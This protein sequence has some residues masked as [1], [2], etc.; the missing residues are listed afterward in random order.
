MAS[1]YEAQFAAVVRRIGTYARAHLCEGDST[2][3]VAWHPENQITVRLQLRGDEVWVVAGSG[4]LVRVVAD[5]FGD[6]LHDELDSIVR[7]I[8]DGYATEYFGV[9]GHPSIADFATGYDLG[10][11]AG[12]AGGRNAKQSRFQARI[13]GPL[14]KAALH[15]DLDLE[16][17]DRDDDVEE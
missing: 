3:A 8:L 14:A 13:A 11:A 6:L 1:S 7:A 5:S 4:T 10:R 16:V 15:L 17:P 2:S 12:F 9:A